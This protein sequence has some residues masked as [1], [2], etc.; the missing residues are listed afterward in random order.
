MNRTF[1][2]VMWMI[3]GI[4]LII[5]GIICLSSPSAGLSAISLLLG[6]F[7]LVS[8]IIDIMVFARGHNIMYGAGWFLADGILTVIMA[9]FILFNQTFVTLTLPFI[10]GMWMLFSGITRFVQSFELRR[11]A[12]D[13]WGWFTVLGT[14]L[15]LAGILSFIAP[16]ISFIAINLMLGICLILRGISS[17]IHAI[18]SGHLFM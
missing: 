18:F 1:S 7:L 11:M 9:L 17:I 12:V 2:K 15:A 4:F 3:A 6:S 14:V 13:G 8:G 16:V 10:F 5:A